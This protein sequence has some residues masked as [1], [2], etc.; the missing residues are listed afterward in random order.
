MKL[1]IMG[2]PGSGKTTLAEK[3][4]NELQAHDISVAWFNADVVRKV[5]GNWDFTMEG[6]IKQC[7]NID[8]L[9]RNSPADVALCDFIA[10]TDFLRRLFNADYVV[11]LDTVSYCRFEDTNALFEPPTN[12]DYV[13]ENHDDSHTEKII[14]DIKQWIHTKSSD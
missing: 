1:L 6:R 11:W 2:L 7:I 13:I 8:E 12:A 5:S 9:A 4:Y 10:P 14:E 3:L